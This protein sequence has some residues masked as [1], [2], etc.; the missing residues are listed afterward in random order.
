MGPASPLFLLI[1]LQVGVRLAIM[2]GVAW[3]SRQYLWVTLTWCLYKRERDGVGQAWGNERQRFSLTPGDGSLETR[4]RSGMLVGFGNL[5]FWV[6]SVICSEGW[7]GPCQKEE[8]LEQCCTQNFGCLLPRPAV[9]GTQNPS[10]A[11]PVL[12]SVQPSPSF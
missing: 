2:Q 4:G 6:T 11:L 10:P 8:E 12:S 3:G 7:K 5:L 9:H 1:G